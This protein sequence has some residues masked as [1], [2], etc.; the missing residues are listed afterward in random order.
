MKKS[1]LLVL[2]CFFIFS[3]CSLNDSDSA[4]PQELQYLWHL[5]QVT[6][7]VAGVDERFDVGDIVWSFDEDTNILTVENNNTDDTIEDGLDSGT[8]SFS[9]LDID[10]ITYLT[11]DGNELGSFVVNQS[12]FTLDQNK[13]STGTGADGFIYLFQLETRAV[14]GN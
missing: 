5:I 2:S 3:N 12:T 11:V 10:G 13:M 4:P 1:L 6:G 7:G 14:E 9:V 8:Y